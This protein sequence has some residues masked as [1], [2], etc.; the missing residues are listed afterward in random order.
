MEKTVGIIGGMGPMATNDLYN[1]IINNTM[2]KS[3]KEHLHVIIDSNTKIPDRTAFIMNGGDNPS[4]ALVRSALKLEYMGADFIIMP[5]NTAHY[6][7]EAIKNFADIPIL[8][9]IEETARYIEEKG[10]GKVLL[11]ATEGTYKTDIYKQEFHKKAME[12]CYPDIEERQIINEAIY[13]VKSGDLSS[14]IKVLDIVERYRQKGVDSIVLGCTELPVLFKD[15]KLSIG[16]VDP[17]LVLAKAAVAYS[18]DANH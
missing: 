9:I 15:K 6:F 13:E 5:C 4:K 18:L 2:A 16:V 12:L 8:N 11:L 7:I 14:Y 17:T 1:K 10:Y 3:D